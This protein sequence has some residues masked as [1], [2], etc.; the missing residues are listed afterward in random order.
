MGSSVPKEH[1]GDDDCQKNRSRKGLLDVS[2][3]HLAFGDV[4]MFLD[5]PVLLRH[6]DC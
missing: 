3:L 2:E 5:A 1:I 6:R 4:A